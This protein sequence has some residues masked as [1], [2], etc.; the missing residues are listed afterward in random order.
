MKSLRPLSSQEMLR[1]AKKKIQTTEKPVYAPEEVELFSSR[2]KQERQKIYQRIR[3][4]T[5]SLT[6]SRQAGEEAADVGSDDFIRETGL[7]IMSDDAEKLQMIDDA[8]MNL[9]KGVYGVC[10][11]CGKLIGKPRLEAKPYARLCITCKEARESNDGMPT[12]T[13]RARYLDRSRL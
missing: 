3:S 2:L 8:L 12:D 5:S 7:S 4:A 13:E 11:D 9:E 10:L 1:M 6:T